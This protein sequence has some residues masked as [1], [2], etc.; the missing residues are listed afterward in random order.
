MTSNPSP[1]YVGRVAAAFDN[2]G[3]GVR[4]DMKA[5]VKA[6]LLDPEARTVSAVDSAGKVREPVLR[7]S[8]L[9]RA[10]N[11]TLDSGRYTGIGLTDDPATQPGPDA[12]AR[13]DGVQLLPSGL[14]AAEQGDRRREAGRFPRCRSRHDVSVAGYMNYIRDL[15]RS[16]T[17]TRDIQH[18]Y[19]AEMALA[20]D[21]G[22]AGRAD[23]PAAVLGHDAGRPQDADRRG[24]RQP[25]DPGPGLP[26]R[27]RR[28][29]RFRRR[30]RPTRR[31]STPRKLDRVYLA[32]FLSMA[33][34]DYL[35]QK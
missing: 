1:A 19:D 23:E 16:S 31:R 35:I 29:A 6:I 34:P 26:A 24:G 14:R 25:G 9:L 30:R 11:A 2:N 12:D 8:H 32:V 4:G 7:L 15:D 27:H 22:G 3:S 20:D 21:A 28:R 13:A 18:N 33:S 17:P 10:F 5:V